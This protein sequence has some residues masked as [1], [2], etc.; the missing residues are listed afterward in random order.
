ME[1]QAERE[2]LI[3][4]LEAEGFLSDPR[5]EEAMLQVPRHHFVPDKL[6]EH[7]YA[8]HPLPVAHDQTLSAPHMVAWMTSLLQLQPG[9]HVLEIGTGVGYQAGVLAAMVP[10][11]RVTSVEWLEPLAKAAK[12]NLQ[13]AG[14]GVDVRQ[15]DGAD[16]CPDNAP[17]DA[18]LVTCAIVDVPPALISQLKEGGHLVAPVGIELSQL[19][20]GRKSGAALVW[21]DHGACRF[22]PGQGRLGYPTPSD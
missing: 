2:A 12:A 9:H 1:R 6:Q 20:V 8:D 5:L 18:I 16:G 4:Q 15:G 14:L 10:D 19:R 17:F 22:V 21:E 3:A 7:A 11:G 13:A